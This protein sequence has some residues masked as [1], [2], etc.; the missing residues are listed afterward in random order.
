MH[1]QTSPDAPDY[2]RSLLSRNL[3]THSLWRGHMREV[4]V[5]EVLKWSQAHIVLNASDSAIKASP[6]P[7][8][9]FVITPFIERLEEIKAVPVLEF[10]L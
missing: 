8:V 3:N 4:L 5:H 6:T 9:L 1:I 10:D 7:K 2:R